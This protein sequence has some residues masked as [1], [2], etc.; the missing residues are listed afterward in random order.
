[1]GQYRDKSPT[2]TSSIVFAPSNQMDYELELAA[3]V[4]KPVAMR[5]RLKATEADEHIFGFVLLND[6]SG[7]LPSGER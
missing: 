5:Q 4:G 3:V 6:W 2:G 1:M 7:E